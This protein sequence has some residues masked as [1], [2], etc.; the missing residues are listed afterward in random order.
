MHNPSFEQSLINTQNQIHQTD[1]KIVSISIWRKP[2]SRLTFLWCG[3][4][5]RSVLML[6]TLQTSVQQNFEKCRQGARYLKQDKT[7]QRNKPPSSTTSILVYKSDGRITP[8]SVVGTPAAFLPLFLECRSCRTASWFIDLM[9][10]LF[11]PC[12]TA[13]VQCHG[14]HQGTCN[15]LRFQQRHL[16]LCCIPRQL[17][18]LHNSVELCLVQHYFSTLPK[19]NWLCLHHV[20]EA[21]RGF[22]RKLFFKM[23][24][25]RSIHIGHDLFQMYSTLFSFQRWTHLKQRIQQ[26]RGHELW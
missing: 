19:V 15:C 20:F 2:M 10:W 24:K 6:W 17:F 11:K 13:E 21:S 18:S 26:A 12:N 14:S 3:P 8:I 16:P 22:W 5:S 25:K 4:Q 9:N 7:S 1:I 23:F